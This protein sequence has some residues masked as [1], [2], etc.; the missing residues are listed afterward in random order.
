MS[1]T[2]TNRVASLAEELYGRFIVRLAEEQRAA[3]R[4]ACF[5]LHAEPGAATY[6]EP[7]TLRVM[8]PADF[9]V[10][11]RRNGGGPCRRA[12][13]VLDGAG[14]GLDLAAMIPLLHDLSSALTRNYEEGD[15]SVDILCYTMF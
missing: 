12:I 1:S 4:L 11:G 8:K 2:E 10:P 13:G 9:R 3:G 15:G 6:L 7:V 14:Q 5:P